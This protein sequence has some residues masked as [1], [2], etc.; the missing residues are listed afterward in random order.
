MGKNLHQNQQLIIPQSVNELDYIEIKDD[1][2][3]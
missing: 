2:I 1:I 3:K